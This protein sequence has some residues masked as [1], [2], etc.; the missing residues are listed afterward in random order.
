MVLVYKIMS[1]GLEYWEGSQHHGPNPMLGKTKF[2]D[3]ETWRKF[4]PFIGDKGPGILP[5]RIGGLIKF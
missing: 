3:W 5:F 2:G 1:Y 4:H